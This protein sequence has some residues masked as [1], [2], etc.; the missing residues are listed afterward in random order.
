MPEYVLCEVQRLGF[1]APT[2]IQ[3]QGWPMALLGRDMI[4]IAFTGSG[5]TVAFSIPLIIRSLERERKRPLRSGEVQEA[6]G[7]VLQ[8]VLHE[9]HPLHVRADGGRAQVSVAWIVVTNSIT[10]TVANMFPGDFYY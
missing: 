7:P 6:V 4:G 1:K 10:V 8:G 2:P 3:S 9:P 5:K